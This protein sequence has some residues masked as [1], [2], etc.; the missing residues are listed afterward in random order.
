[1]DEGS[2]EAEEVQAK[3][4]EFEARVRAMPPGPALVLLEDYLRKLSKT[5]ALF[6]ALAAGFLWT[7]QV[8]DS[9]VHLLPTVGA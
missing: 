9:A 6:A 4:R 5:A 3:L 2:R 8:A 1:V 7:Q